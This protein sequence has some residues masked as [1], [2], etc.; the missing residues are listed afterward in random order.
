MNE[1]RSEIPLLPL[2]VSNGQIC[3]TTT[4]K[5]GKNGYSETLQVEGLVPLAYPQ[6]SLPRV[7]EHACHF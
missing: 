7:K 5:G 4:R 3:K 2:T 1:K 6:S